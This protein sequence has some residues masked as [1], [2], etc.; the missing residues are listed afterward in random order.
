MYL[1]VRE[2]DIHAQCS[3][4]QIGLEPGFLRKVHEGL[5]C[6]TL[7]PF[8]TKAIVSPWDG[9]PTAILKRFMPAKHILRRIVAPSLSQIA[10]PR[11]GLTM[12][13]PLRG[14]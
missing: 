6:G 8:Q 11:E 13:G 7:L 2:K 5:Q 3:I 1:H 12:A 9:D 4:K 14:C 10:S